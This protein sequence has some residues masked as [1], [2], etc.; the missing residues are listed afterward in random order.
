MLRNSFVNPLPGVPDVESPFFERIFA[1]KDLPP[2]TMALAIQLRERGYAIFDFPDPEFGERA[3]RIKAS[4]GP[5]FDFDA[6]RSTL[7]E[8]NVGMRT[9]DAWEHNTDVRAMA[10]NPQVLKIL[11][12][13]YG[14]RA[15]PF[16]TLNFPVGTQQAT[17]NDGAHFYSAP[18]RFMCGVWVAL[19]D[20]TPLNGGLEYYPGSHKIP[21]YT[22]EHIGA[23]SAE[24]LQP[25]EHYGALLN[26]WQELIDQLGIPRETFYAKKG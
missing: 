17:H 21:Q 19:E 4:L 13:L 10:T 24:Q 22:N 5:Q 9:Q 25:T 23:C 20:I 16:Q 14:R 3:E 2:E 26:L 15:L 7:S 1:G 6:W 11:E 8:T 18:E 12:D